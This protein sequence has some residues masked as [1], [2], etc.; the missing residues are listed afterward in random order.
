MSTV[1]IA[2]TAYLVFALLIVVVID[3][4]VSLLFRETTAVHIRS[5]AFAKMLSVSRRFPWKS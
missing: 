4:V 2:A 5:S 3:N 1:V